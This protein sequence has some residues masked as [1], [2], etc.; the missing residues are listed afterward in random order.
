M[1]SIKGVML[2]GVD[3]PAY[4]RHMAHH[5]Y[6]AKLNS[7]IRVPDPRQELT[8]LVEDKVR[9][10]MLEWFAPTSF[11]ILRWEE[12]DASNRYKIKFRELDGVFHWNTGTTVLLEVKASA[13]KSSLK[14]GL[15]QLQAAVNTLKHANPRVI[16]ILVIADLAEWYDM[17]GQA[18]ATP[19]QDYFSELNVNFLGW[20]PVFAGENTS[21]ICVSLVPHAMLENWLD[22]DENETP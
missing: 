19:L 21:A 6:I 17:F 13:S 4:L 11:R 7:G 8:K 1:T 5:T 9:A 16:G 20:P 10:A 15:T 12:L 2:L 22:L 18:A 14:S 3:S